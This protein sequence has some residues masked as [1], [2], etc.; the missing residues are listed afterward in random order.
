MILKLGLMKMR[1]GR[2]F[3]D[4]GTGIKGKS[5]QEYHFFAFVD[6]HPQAKTLCNLAEAFNFE[7]WSLFSGENTSDE[8]NTVLD[9]FS[10]D[11]PKHI[12]I[13]M[14]TVCKQYIT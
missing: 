5:R 6:S 13:A 8:K 10:E 2:L 11:L 3:F 14:E 7:V 4:A 1:Q 9:Y 12:N